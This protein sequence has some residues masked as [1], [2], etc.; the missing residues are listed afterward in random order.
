MSDC[1]IIGGG[2]IGITTARAMAMAGAK[3][4][5]LDQRACGKESSW[6]GGG[7]I[8]P[9]YPW[10]YSDL[11]NELSR[12]SQG[13]YAHLCAELFENTGID[14]EYIRCGLLMMDKYNTPE[15]Q[16]W[17]GK[18]SLDFQVHD[19]GA[20]FKDIAQVRNPRLLKALKADILKLGVQVVEQ[21]KVN[22]LMTE[23]GATLGAITE[24]K[25]Y[26][27]DN[28]IVCSGAW[29]SSLL[30]I[31][32]TIYPIKGQMIVIKAKAGAVK[33]IILDQGRYIIPRKDGRLLIGSTME[34]VGFDRSIQTQVGADLLAFAVNRFPQLKNTNIEHHWAGFRPASSAD[35]I[36][37]KHPQLANLYINAGHFRNGLNMAPESA[38]RIKKLLC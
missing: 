3:V 22:G 6:A 33:H 10:L 34:N 4:T 17:M 12:A 23:K 32:D 15:A 8:S 21:A 11:V 30:D 20:L 25:K 28:T 36:V 35:V 13:V 2:V 26:Y 38:N 16:Q 1:L 31:K 5:L 19:K 37:G 14:P 9:L 24:N 18:H 27:A 29:S 7:I